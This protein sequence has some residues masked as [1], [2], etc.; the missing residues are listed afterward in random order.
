[1]LDITLHDRTTDTGPLT[2][3]IEK[4]TAG[5]DVDVVINDSKAGNTPSTL[6]G[7]TVRMALL[8]LILGGGGPP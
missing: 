6:N 2:V 1:M 3:E 5:D 8:D 4:I 7:V